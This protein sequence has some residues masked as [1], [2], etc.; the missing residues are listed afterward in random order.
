[1]LGSHPGYKVQHVRGQGNG[2]AH[3][4]VRSSISFSKHYVFVSISHC[5]QTDL[6]M[7]MI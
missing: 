6:A 4:L 1:M 3:T 7:E 2:I 5:I